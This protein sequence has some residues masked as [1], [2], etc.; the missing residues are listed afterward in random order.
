MCLH[1]YYYCFDFQTDILPGML[2]DVILATAALRSK[3][4]HCSHV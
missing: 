2:I 3:N 1:I 4:L